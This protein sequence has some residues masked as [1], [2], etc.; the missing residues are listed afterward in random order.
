MKKIVIIF[1]YIFICS[2][3][4]HI[5]AQTTLYPVTFIP[6]KIDGKYLQNPWAGG[7]NSAQPQLIDLNNDALLDLA[8]YEK[9]ENKVLTFINV[10]TGGNPPQYLFSPDYAK[11][12]PIPNSWMI[13]KDYSCDG[14]ADLFTYGEL[15]EFD[16]YIGD[17]EADTIHFT[18]K[19]KGAYYTSGANS[20]NVYATN[21]DK[22]SLIDVNGDGDLDYITFNVGGTNFQYY[23]NLQQELS[24]PCDSLFFEFY[25]PCWG[26]ILETGLNVQ[27]V[28]NDTCSDSPMHREMKTLHVGS[29]IEVA[30]INGDGNLDVLLGDISLNL[31]NYLKNGSSS[32]LASFLEQDIQYPSY[33]VPVALNYFPAPFVT[34]INQDGNKDLLVSPFDGVGGDNVQNIW[35]YQNNS[36]DS[37][38]LEFK[39]KNYL[40]DNM[41]DFG[42][43]AKPCIADVDGDG[44]K[45]ILIANGGIR[46]SGYTAPAQ[47]IY[48]KNIGTREYPILTLVD[49]NF[50]NIQ[51]LNILNLSISSSDYDNDSDDDLVLGLQDGT[52]L[53][54][55]NQGG[56]FTAKGNIKDISN[57]KID[58]GQDATPC[59]ADL[60]R[61]GKKDLIIGERNGNI[62]YYICHDFSTLQYQFITDSLGKITTRTAL[63]PYGYSSPTI[64]DFDGDSKADLFTGSVLDTIYF[65]SN[66]AANITSK[67]TVTSKQILPHYLGYRLFPVFGDL[68]NDDKAECLIGSFSGGVYFY[69]PAPPDE[70]PL[71][72]SS[73]LE[74]TLL[75]FPNPSTN[76][77]YV[78]GLKKITDYDISNT[79]GQILLSD[80]VHN[81]PIDLGM[82]PSGIYII[83][84][85]MDDSI[86]SKK[87]I[88]N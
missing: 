84:F 35:Y 5:D 16:V 77:V 83:T 52:M 76:V 14:I 32:T 26:Y 40:T 48:L 50:L 11:Y 57:V 28:L 63:I 75:L 29:T 55:Q 56:I 87:I 10:S 42:E 9:S 58:V 20:I 37:L 41:L 44:L 15:G 25:H 33:D 79:F 69:S 80:K 39:Q 85:Y 59:W 19:Q 53:C 67:K 43:W 82:L 22:P 36:S 62:N 78:N 21:I 61:D 54:Y 65:Y 1:I 27:V 7:I 18:R 88:K 47:V 71:S 2:I 8:I 46:I 17:F 74:R 64:T 73:Y 38:L 45:D 4:N 68:T 31:L 66:I 72:L 60:N 49:S 70:R 3:C 51:D 13:C 6:V 86:V 23:E 34:D 24:L 30:D 12:F 81:E